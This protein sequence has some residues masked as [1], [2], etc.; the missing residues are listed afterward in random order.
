MVKSFKYWKSSFT[1]R[2]IF[3]F[4]ARYISSIN[5]YSSRKKGALKKGR[6]WKREHQFRILKI[7]L[8]LTNWQWFWYSFYCILLYVTV[9]AQN[10]F[11]ISS[12]CFRWMIF[13]ILF[14]ILWSLVSSHFMLDINVKETRKGY[15]WWCKRIVLIKFLVPLYGSSYMKF[16]VAIFEVLLYRRVVK[17]NNYFQ[18]E[19]SFYCSQDVNIF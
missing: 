13:V 10:R 12:H 7:K 9:S 8:R 1:V 16:Y 17:F 4:I 11:L 15:L 2:G 19:F 6:P 18:F 14:D 3:G 5:N